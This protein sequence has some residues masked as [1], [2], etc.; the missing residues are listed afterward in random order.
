[1]DEAAGASGAG[2]RCGSAGVHYGVEFLAAGA[3]RDARAWCAADKSTGWDVSVTGNITKRYGMLRT[4]LLCI[5]FG[6]LL[7]PIK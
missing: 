6:L 1:M 5:Y 2:A 3:A 7:R 4:A